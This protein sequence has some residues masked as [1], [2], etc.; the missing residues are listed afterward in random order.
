MYL[1][2]LTLVCEVPIC[3]NVIKLSYFFL[4]NLSHVDLIEQ[5]KAPRSLE[6][7]VFFPPQPPHIRRAQDK[8]TWGI[9]PF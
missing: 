8:S 4:V 1:G 9:R 5:P 2:T 6:E 7:S 3:M